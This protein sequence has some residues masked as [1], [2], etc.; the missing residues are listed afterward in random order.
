MKYMD[1]S[2]VKGTVVNDRLIKDA[3]RL[4]Y[5]TY[6]RMPVVF[7]RGEGVYL[8][9]KAG[10]EYLDFGAGISVV[11]LG[12]GNTHFNQ[13]IKEQVDKGLL[14]CS[15]LFYNEPAIEAAEKLL[16]LSGMDRVFFTNSGAEA[17]EGAIKIVRRYQYDKGRD[18]TE[19]IAFHGS[20]HGR[21]LGALSV[22]GKEEY[23]APF[24]PL[25]P[26]VHFAR[27]NDLD[28]VKALINEHTGGIIL[29]ALQGEGGIYEAD[30]AFL[31]GI[32]ELC[33]EHE[34]LLV[35]DEIQCGMG[36]TGYSFAWQEYGIKPD[37]M[38]VAKALGNGMPIGA[39]LASGE[40]AFSLKPGDHGSTYGGNP[41]VCAAASAVLD[42][43]K[44][45]NIALRAR[46]S[47]ELL[48]ELLLEIV[49]EFPELVRERRGKGLIQ[50]LEFNACISAGAVAE[51]ALLSE[52]LVLISAS[53]NTLRFVPP[54][55]IEKSQI[56]D[57][58]DRLRRVLGS[59]EIKK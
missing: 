30:E 2:I 55:I 45:E 1:E 32:R 59:M 31:K 41:L 39:F 9:D 51:R 6:N 21:T 15:N 58:G 28:S 25:L 35:M 5:K 24:E 23:R 49:E 17:I 42:I 29:E 46:H 38:T 7:D 50:G 37:I 16:E 18:K 8:Y 53:H 34:L 22:T 36:R 11:G 44:E 4:L 12:Y 48:K 20:F 14:H 56:R 10:R 26:K 19:L 47:G 3:D 43:F 57:M 13:A 40:A 27:Y 54:L 33:D 52:R